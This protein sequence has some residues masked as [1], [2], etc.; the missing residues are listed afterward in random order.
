MQIIYHSIVDAEALG[1][2]NSG[3]FISGGGALL[4]NTGSMFREVFEMPYLVAQPFNYASRGGINIDS[5]RY[6]AVWGALKYA[7][8]KLQE[9]NSSENGF[10]GSLTSGIDRIWSG[11]G[12]I[13]KT[14]K[15]FRV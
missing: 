2:I 4:P 11:A 8:A 1:N 15:G 7:Q 9:E 6:S 14:F 12:I 13:L 3:A 5:P 10:V